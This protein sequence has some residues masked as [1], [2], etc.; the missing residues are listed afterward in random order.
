[1][2]KPEFSLVKALRAAA[3]GERYDALTEAIDREARAEMRNAGRSSSAQLVLP[4]EKRTITVTTEHDD[5]IETE[6]ENILTPLWANRVLNNARHITGLIGDVQFPT[7]ADDS[8]VAW[9]GEITQNQESNFTFGNIQLKP[10]RLST[11]IFLSKQLLLQDSI[12]VENAVRQALMDAIY[13]KIEKTF[14]SKTA[15]AGNVPGGIFAGLTAT[16][17]T[18]FKELCEF[19][20]GAEKNN[21]AGSLT[22]LLSPDAKAAIRGT[23]TY[24][25]KTTRMVMEGNEIDGTPYVSTNNMAAKEFAY[26]NWND[27][28]IGEWGQ[29]EVSVDSTSVQMARNAQVAI[30]VNLWLDCKVL[31]SQAVY[32]GT[33]QAAQGGNG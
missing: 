7:M 2:K 3:N 11:T 29:M 16:P 31:R 22:Y 21:Y 12:G 18:S 14:L 9:E 33:V 27:V 1:M 30:T 8:N 15:A 32:L 13:D 20:A 17:V 10:H 4:L 23:M 24:G 26:L 25:G 5:V 28:V 19:E 6:F